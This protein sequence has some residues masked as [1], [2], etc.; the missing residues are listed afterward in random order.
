MDDLYGL[1]ENME[2][3][4]NVSE[5][6]YER[7][8]ALMPIHCVDLVVDCG[9][10]AILLGKRTNE[11]AKGYW[12]TPG[13]R[14]Y[15]GRTTREMVHILAEKE[16]GVDMEIVE[17]LGNYDHFYNVSEFGDVS[18]HTPV[19]AYVVRP[20]EEDFEPDSQHEDLRI[21]SE[22]PDN[23]HPYTERYVEDARKAGL[24]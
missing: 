7:I 9:D 2:V 3:V 14:Q 23:T 19:T 17:Q 1:P 12:F 13:G 24:L 8:V 16:L 11:P 10:G 21:F 4:E 15:K 5:E 18:K 22:L 6:E 20:L